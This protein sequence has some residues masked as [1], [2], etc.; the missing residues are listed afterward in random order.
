MSVRLFVRPFCLLFECHILICNRFN[1]KKNIIK[2]K[3]HIRIQ[4]KK[5]VWIQSEKNLD[6][7]KTLDP[8]SIKIFDPDSTKTPDLDPTKTPDPEPIKT[9]DLDLIKTPDQDPT[10]T[11]D[12]DPIKTL[13]PDAT[14]ILNSGWRWYSADMQMSYSCCHIRTSFHISNVYITAAEKHLDFFFDKQAL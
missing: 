12:L 1:L 13:N 14:L 7:T 10:K 4:H 9:P 6:P 2:P 11:P 5:K 8:D 3:H